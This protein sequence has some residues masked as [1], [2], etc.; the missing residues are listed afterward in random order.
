MIIIAQSTIHQG[1]A[2]LFQC[3][4][5]TKFDYQINPRKD[6]HAEYKCSRCGKLLQWY[7][8]VQQIGHK[9]LIGPPQPCK[10][11]DRQKTDALVPEMIK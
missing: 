7:H 2:M 5:E 11:P 1:N 4:C 10:H 3:S 6:T 9:S 8:P